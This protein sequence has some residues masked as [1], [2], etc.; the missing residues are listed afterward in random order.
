[1][2]VEGGAKV[3]QAEFLNRSNHFIQRYAS[4]SMY[5]DII[6]GRSD[7]L[8]LQALVGSVDSAEGFVGPC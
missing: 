4:I 2:C 6:V 3:G 8:L 1:M 5:Y 7:M